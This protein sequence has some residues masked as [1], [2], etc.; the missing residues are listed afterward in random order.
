M[1]SIPLYSHTAGHTC[2]DALQYFHDRSGGADVTG[3]NAYLGGFIAG[4]NASNGD[5]YE[6]ALY[7]T[8]SASFTVEQIGLPRLYTLPPFPSQWSDQSQTTAEREEGQVPMPKTRPGSNESGSSGCL[9][10]EEVDGNR[11]E[12]VKRER[13][14]GEI[15]ER[16]LEVL[17]K[18]LRDWEVEAA[19]HREKPEASQ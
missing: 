1:V 7:G 6:A 14:N 8:I 2:R 17:R 16:R 13:W 11:G 10:E 3:G 12:D 4:L 18:K 19:I 9:A 15:P 5:P